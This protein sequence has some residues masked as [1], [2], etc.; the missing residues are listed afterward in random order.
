MGRVNPTG[1]NTPDVITPAQINAL[2]IKASNA[3][4]GVN[5]GSYSPAN[6]L[7][8]EANFTA[9]TIAGNAFAL[10]SAESRQLWFP[11]PCTAFEAWSVTQY[12]Y[13]SQLS[14]K[15][16]GAGFSPYAWIMLPTLPKNAIVTGA[17]V[18]VLGNSGHTSLPTNKVRVGLDVID[19]QGH[20]VGNTSLVDPSASVAAYE[21]IH[22][23]GVTCNYQTTDSTLFRI[24][25]TGEDNSTNSPGVTLLSA[26]VSFTCAEIHP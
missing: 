25:V 11:V 17:G 4:D 5:G 18:T 9:Q 22:V 12:G 23:V 20:S 24:L 3:V 2:D 6:P 1:W 19:T 15:T 14:S 21:S 10:R 13:L 8:V 7:V 26:Y 16:S